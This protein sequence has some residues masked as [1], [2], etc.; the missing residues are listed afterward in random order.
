MCVPAC[1]RARVLIH[2][3]NKS[4]K[5]TK[6]LQKPSQH[7]NKN[8]Q[9][10]IKPTVTQTH[11]IYSQY[12]ETKLHKQRAIHREQTRCRYIYQGI[13]KTQLRNSIKPDATDAAKSRRLSPVNTKRTS[14][15]RGNSRSEWKSIQKSCP[16][17]FHSRLL[18]KNSLNDSFTQ[19]PSGKYCI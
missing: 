16:Y 1:A 8:P 15:P 7:R 13:T 6:T 9:N 12:P 5:E 2:L 3:L 19:D 18:C 17:I 11:R 10:K 14:T 4:G